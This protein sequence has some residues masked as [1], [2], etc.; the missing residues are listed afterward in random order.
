MITSTNKLVRLNIFSHL[1]INFTISEPLE[2][3]ISSY[4]TLDYNKFKKIPYSI[5]CNNKQ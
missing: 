1:S 2:M 3:D 5:N 4:L